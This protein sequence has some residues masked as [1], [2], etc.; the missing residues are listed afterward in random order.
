MS[1]IINWN[2]AKHPLNW[3][4]VMLMVMIGGI[5]IELAITAYKSHAT[6]VTD[7]NTLTAG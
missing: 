3:L 2:I 1:D 5:A 6:K 7:Q 4:I